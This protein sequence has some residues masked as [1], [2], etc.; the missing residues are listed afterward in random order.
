MIFSHSMIQQ[1]LFVLILKNK[2]IIILQLQKKIKLLIYLRSFITLRLLLDLVFFCLGI[3]PPDGFK[4][5]CELS[6]VEVDCSE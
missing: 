1:N 2:F 5:K 6:R 3:A 4:Y